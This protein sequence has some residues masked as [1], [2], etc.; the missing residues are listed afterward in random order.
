LYFIIAFLGSP[1]FFPATMLL[2]KAGKKGGGREWREHAISL[3]ARTGE[4]SSSTVDSTCPPFFPAFN[5]S[6]VAGKKGGVG[7]GNRL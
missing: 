4:H 3:A 6:I 7:R 1:P 5:N 2:L